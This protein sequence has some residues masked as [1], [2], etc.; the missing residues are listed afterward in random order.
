MIKRKIGFIG[1]GKMAEALVRG[2]L[3]A[4]CI[5]PAGIFAADISEQRRRA[6]AKL[7]GRNV[8]A[9]KARV[10][11]QADVIVLSVKPQVLPGV[12]EEI[13]PAITGRHL[14]VSIAPG[15]TLGWLGEK[16][17]T[18]RLIRVMPNTPALLGQGAAG[19]A[20]G[21]GATKADAALVREM[22]SAV[23]I[24]EEVDEKLMDA[25]TGLSGSGPAYIYTVI[26]A[27]SDGGVKMGL[28]REVATR[29][30]AQT[31]LGAARMVIETGLPPSELRDQVTTPGGTT[32]EGLHVL[33]KAHVRKAFMDAVRAATHKSKLLGKRR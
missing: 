20:R 2:M 21:A 10:I 9:D 5:R 13:A 14:L 17:G 23:G 32:I 22:L 3:K 18:R 27:M 12:L 26:E 25:V 19:F 15:F 16:L 30:A 1:A 24:C 8:P 7:I 11:E 28:P 31:V 6:F 33:E 4:K 29:L